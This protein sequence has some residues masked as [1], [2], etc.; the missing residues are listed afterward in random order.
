[1]TIH[2]PEWLAWVVAVVFFIAN[3]SNFKQGLMYIYRD[4]IA[5]WL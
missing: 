4:F 1:M 5:P 3:Y 2:I